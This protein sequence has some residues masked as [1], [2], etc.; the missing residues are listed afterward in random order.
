[1]DLI[2]IPSTV[3]PEE[4]NDRHFQDARESYGSGRE[5]R[6]CVEKIAERGFIPLQETI[7]Q[8]SHHPSAIQTFLDPKHCVRQA[9][10]DHRIGGRRIQGVADVTV[11]PCV[12]LVHEHLDF[13]IPLG[14]TYST[15]DFKAPQMRTE[16]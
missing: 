12:L 9:C 2:A 16:Q 5:S 14:N 6:K 1:M 7:P 13:D 3:E 11:H 4:E 8:N 15:H 10:L